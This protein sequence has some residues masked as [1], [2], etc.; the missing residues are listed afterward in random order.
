MAPDIFKEN[1]ARQYRKSAD[2]RQ[3]QRRDADAPIIEGSQTRR[4]KDPQNGLL[5][6]IAHDKRLLGENGRKTMTGHASYSRLAARSCGQA[7]GQA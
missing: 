6:A 5:D 1:K 2:E 4:V 7:V 3:N